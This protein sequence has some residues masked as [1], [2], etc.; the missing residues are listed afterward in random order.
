MTTNGTIVI[1]DAYHPTRRLA[2]EFRKAGYECIRVQSTETVPM[3]YR[4]TLSLDDYAANIVHR[5]DLAETVAAAAAHDPVAVVPGGEFGVEFADTLSEAMGLPS[6]GTALSAARRDKYT[7][8]E[9][10]KAAGVAGAEQ[11]L[12]EDADHLRHW[13]E[14]LGRRVVVKPIR[15]TAGDGIFFCDTPEDSV[16]AYQQLSTAENVFSVR[17]AGVVA[18]EYLRGGEYVVNTVSRDG[19]H[20]VTDIWKTT[21]LSANGVLDLC[22][23]IYLIARESPDGEQLAQYAHQ[24]LGALG[25]QHGPA[26]LEVKLTPAGPRLVEIGARIAGGDIPHYA[27][28]AIGESQL[29]WTADAY[30]DPARFLQRCDEKYRIEKHFASVAMIS[31][32]SGTLRGYRH[33]DVIEKLESF[34]EMRALV[35]PGDEIRPTVDDL[36]YPMIVNL[37]HEVEEVTQRDFATLRFLDGESFYELA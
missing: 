13:H 27:Q 35:K 33:L 32:V 31:P 11:L 37:R 1:V 18:Q 21:R 23:G 2:P 9:T 30:V 8:I 26:H 5:G 4:A 17:N 28:L 16:R 7:M 3:V 20:H 15:S 36:T 24:V 25:I 19:H 6:N 12:V 34:L 22:D 14:Q 29:D 10:I